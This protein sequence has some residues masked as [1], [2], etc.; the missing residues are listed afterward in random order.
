MY[1]LWVDCVLGYEC[2]QHDNPADFFLDV[3]FYNETEV[4][5]GMLCIIDFY[6][7]LEC[8]VDFSNFNHYYFVSVQQTIIMIYY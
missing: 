1:K 8:L 5:K 7:E 3:V 6:K 2:E 4:T